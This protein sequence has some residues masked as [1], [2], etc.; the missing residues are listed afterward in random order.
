M[1]TGA[2]LGAAEKRQLLIV[3]GVVATSAL[4]AAQSIAPRLLDYVLLATRSAEPGHQ[5]QTEALGLKPL[6]DSPHG[7][8]DGVGAALAMPLL[9][10]AAGCLKSASGLAP[11]DHGQ[12]QT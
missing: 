9:R 6:L 5:Q 7:D 1:M 2:M 4:I 12:Q 8:G 11:A 3:D 10:L